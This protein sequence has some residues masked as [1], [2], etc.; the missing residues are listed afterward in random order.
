MWITERFF[1]IKLV[2]RAA[3]ELQSVCLLVVFRY[4]AYAGQRF[5]QIARRF[6]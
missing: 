3:L 2:P 6:K 4:L 1:E 5:F